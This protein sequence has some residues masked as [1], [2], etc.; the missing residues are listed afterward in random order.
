M[1]PTA[2]ASAIVA[3]AFLIAPRWVDFA[4][5]AVPAWVRWL[6]VP[7][8]AVGVALFGWMFRH[9]G[10]NATSTSVPR[11]A[12]T[13]VTSGPYRL[14]RHPMYSAP[15]TLVFATTSLTANA[16]VLASAVA[17]FAL[18]AA[19]SRIEERRLV[20]KFGDAYRA[21]QAR[22]GRFVPQG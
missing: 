1:W 18:L 14:I 12:A 7:V 3:M 13:L 21:Y 2:P 4:R 6:G 15:L 17:M 10:L 19:R 20:E 5:M 8:G 22:M 11:A 9:P 16:A